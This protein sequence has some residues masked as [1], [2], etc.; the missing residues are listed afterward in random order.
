MWAVLSCSTP[1]SS[2]LDQVKQSYDAWSHGVELLDKKDSKKALEAF[3]QA[4][5]S[6][7]QD[8]LLLAWRGKALAASGQVEDAIQ[9]FD[10]VLV[11]E[12]SLSE[13][14]Y[15]RGLLYA[16]EGDCGLSGADIARASI[17]LGLHHGD[18]W[19]D[20]V[21]EA[22]R[23][24]PGFSFLPSV[25]ISVEVRGPQEV[26]LV[27]SKVSLEMVIWGGIP[28]PIHVEAPDISGMVRMQGLS[29][30]QEEG[31]KRILHWKMSIT[32][33]GT[34]ELGPFIIRSGP[35]TAMANSIHFRALQPSGFEGT[36][37]DALPYEWQTPM[38][39]MGSDRPPSVWS[40]G[41][42][43]SVLYGEDMSLNWSGPPPKETMRYTLDDGGTERW[44]LVEYL[45]KSA[46]TQSLTIENTG[47]VL[48]TL[49]V[50]SI[51]STRPSM[52]TLNTP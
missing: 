21:L 20:E 9:V 48:M 40:K 11:L 19:K 26:V 49:P 15:F 7:P 32:E 28:G 12:P 2:D 41:E 14:R 18:I 35:F 24:H 33:G 23:A 42:L 44:F 13:A 30:V 52:R 8:L 43:I 4:I 39:R 6:R 46:M 37:E 27:G 38:E 47:G 51:L 10:K 31:A 36:D 3:D 45:R 29:E 50:S 5:A 17:E 25:P 16:Q 1:A 34:V 22:C